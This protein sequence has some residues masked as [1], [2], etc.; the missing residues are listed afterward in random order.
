M[1]DAEDKRSESE[2][3]EEKRAS[4]EPESEADGSDVELDEA[5]ENEVKRLLRGALKEEPPPQSDVLKGVQRRLRERSGGKFYDDE[6]STSKRTPI[7]IYLVTSALMLAV[8]L[9]AYA[10]MGFLSGKAEP[11]DNTPAPVQI[12]IPKPKSS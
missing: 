11:V 1:S 5:E 6:W 3:D 8:V 7:G 2:S 9:V 12:V 10:V 4:E